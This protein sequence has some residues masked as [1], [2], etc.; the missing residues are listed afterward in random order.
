MD[1]LDTIIEEVM[2][3]HP[4]IEMGLVYEKALHQLKQLAPD[5]Y[6]EQDL[7]QA[8]NDYITRLQEK[9]A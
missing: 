6:S 7:E 4:C 1:N 3:S 9:Y 5:G 8:F 2:A